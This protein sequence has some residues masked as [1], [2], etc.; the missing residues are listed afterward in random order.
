MKKT[1]PIAH[2]KDS[3]FAKATFILGII[4]I[5]ASAYLMIKGA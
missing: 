5:L 1:M 2:K 4:I 3:K